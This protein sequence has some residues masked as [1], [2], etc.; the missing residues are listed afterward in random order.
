MTI[1]LNISVDM[2][3]ERREHAAKAN[4]RLDLQQKDFYQRVTQ[5]YL[6]LAKKF[7]NRYVVIDGTLSVP[8][9][10]SNVWNAVKEKLPKR[11]A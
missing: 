10:S 6:D 7:T 2:G 4:D 9:V 5:G 1:L 11:D 8:D 3:L